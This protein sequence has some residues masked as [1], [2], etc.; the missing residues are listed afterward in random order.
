LAA[1][2]VENIFADILDRAKALDPANA[3]KWF[4]KL[5]ALHLDG[6]SLGVGCPNEA[7]AQFLRD[8]CKSSFTQAAQ[9]ITGYL[10]T[11]DFSV[12]HATL[13]VRA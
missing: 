6:G 5:T 9:Q 12:D 4:E 13:R 2:E 7:T 8:N 1:R 10:V 3:R 11:V